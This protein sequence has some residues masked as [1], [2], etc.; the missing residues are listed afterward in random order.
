MDFR[1]AHQKLP[2]YRAEYGPTIQNV[3]CSSY[4]TLRSMPEAPRTKSAQGSYSEAI[5]TWLLAAPSRMEAPLDLQGAAP[6]SL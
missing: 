2:V 1:R 3:D 5:S 4:A 6:S